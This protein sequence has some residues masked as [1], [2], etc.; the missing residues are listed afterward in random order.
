ME[1]RG[2]GQRHPESRSSSAQN[3]LREA[4]TVSRDLQAFSLDGVAARRP[5]PQ[6][7]AD[8]SSI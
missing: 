5:E 4:A 2:S 1:C 7:A 6:S 3:F 8:L